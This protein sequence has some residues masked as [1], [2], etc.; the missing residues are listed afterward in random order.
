MKDTYRILAE[1]RKVNN[2]TWVTGLNNNDV[3]IGPSGAG[4]TRGYVIP[5][6]LQAEESMIVADTKGS[7]SRIVMRELRKKGYRCQ[8]I[9]FTGEGSSV[10]YNPLDYIRYDARNDTYSAKDMKTIA[11]AIVPI[12]SEKDP[13][14][15]YAGRMYLESMIAYVMECLPKAEHTLTTV[16]RLFRT[17]G[18]GQFNWL[19]K[20]L[21]ELN[22]ESY[23]VSVYEMY[24]DN[25]KAEKMHESIR[26]ILAEKLAVLTLDSVEKLIQN[27]SRVD[28]KEM[29]MRKTALFLKIS[30]TDRSMDRLINLFYMQA[31]H[32]LCSAADRDFV[33]HRLPVPVRLILDDF[34]ANVY[35][36]D[37]DKIT[38]VIRSREISVSIILQSLSQLYS[39]YGEDKAKTILNNCDH[40][41]YLGGQDVDTARYISFKANKSVHSILNMPLENA[42]LFERGKMPLQVEKYHLQMG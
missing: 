1:G 6:I 26:G 30:D 25:M 4:K 19:F 17:M 7:V 24:K 3:I 37:F 18:T 14:W 35:I 11:A 41:L 22:P 2:N 5:N 29:G 34:A 36:P 42:W 20:E 38:S 13:F 12:E 32:E 10:G 16:Q 31:L 23:A 21:T 8:T 33:G 40:C 9:D 28:F 15:D 27:R 39:M